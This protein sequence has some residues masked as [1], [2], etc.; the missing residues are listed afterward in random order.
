MSKLVLIV[1]DEE[2]MRVYLQ[3]IFQKAGYQTE[4]AVNGDDALLAVRRQV[5]DAI[6]LDILMPRRSGLNFFRSLRKTE[7]TKDVPVVV[8]SGITGNSEFFEP[9]DLDGP[10]RF[11]EKP[12]KPEQLLSIVE[13]ML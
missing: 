1:D 12:I 5:P 11:L 13:S 3:T 2:D 6:T 8:V 7:T 4:V 9:A 10:V